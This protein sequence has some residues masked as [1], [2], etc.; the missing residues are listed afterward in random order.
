MEMLLL[1]VSGQ[2]ILESGKDYHD[3][4][5]LNR[6]KMMDFSNTFLSFGIQLAMGQTT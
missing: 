1:H 2:N 5:E 6:Q 4:F 3:V